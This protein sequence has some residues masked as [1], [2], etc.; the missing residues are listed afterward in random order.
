MKVKRGNLLSRKIKIE[1]LKVARD[2]KL[3]VMMRQKQGLKARRVKRMFEFIDD[4]L[5]QESKRIADYN[6]K[7]HITA[8]TFRVKRCHMGLL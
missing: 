6:K 2:R 4:Y 3:E 8:E 5:E 1:A 7:G